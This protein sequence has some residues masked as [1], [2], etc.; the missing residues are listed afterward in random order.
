M[1]VYL[2]GAFIDKED[3]EELLEP[4][5]LFGWG[6][7]ETL[8]V[9]NKR[10]A[11]LEEHLTRMKRGLEFLG[12]ECPNIDFKAAIQRLLGENNLSD[13]YLRIAVFKKRKSIGVVIYGA[14]FT[15][16]KE[17]AY[18]KGAK[19]IFAPSFRCSQDPYLAIKSISYVKSRHAW[20]HA[21]R[22]GKDEAIFLNEKGFIQEGSRSN[23]FFIKDKDFFTPS[24]RC[25]LL[26]GVTRKVVIDICKDEGYRVAEGEFTK[27]D[28]LSA[29][30]AFLVSSLMEVMPISEI[31]GCSLDRQKFTL[32]PLI[33]K[34]YRERVS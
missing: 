19:I 12:L 4:G 17:D 22:Q 25:G 9:Y 30:E 21:Q 13:A 6:V 27:E 34:K 23:I 2:N 32:T 28:L 20:F 11:F 7:F 18:K 24:H 10:V 26:D 16:Y 8:R 15:Y 14:E 5:F 3:I 33:H 31:D 29:D 1:K